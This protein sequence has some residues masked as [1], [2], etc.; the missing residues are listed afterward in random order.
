MMAGC[1]LVG[2]WNLLRMA[3]A[4][5][6]Q[7][8][9]L[10]QAAG[11]R[12]SGHQRRCLLLARC[13]TVTPPWTRLAL[14]T[15]QD[16]IG[17]NMIEDAEARGVIKPGACAPTLLLTAGGSSMPWAWQLGGGCLQLHP[18]KLQ[19]P[20]REGM[21]CSVPGWYLPHKGI[22]LAPQLCRHHDPRGAYERQH[23]HWAG[24]CGGSK[25]VQAHP[26]HAG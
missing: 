10:S 3:A 19:P 21:G 7:A 14:L 18:P 2:G 12:D 17:R 11:E 25:G 23:R 9:E 26:D 24:V 20:C 8:G 5:R 16:R 15:L 6:G 22:G 1:S 13:R 4:H